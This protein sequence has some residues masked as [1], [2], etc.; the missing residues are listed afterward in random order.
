MQSARAQAAAAA[1]RR[2]FGINAGGLF[3]RPAGEWAPMLAQLRR[4]GL[5]VVRQDLSWAAVQP[6][7]DGPFTWAATDRIAEALATAGLRWYPV[8]AYSTAWSGVTPGDMMS[9]PAD[10]ARYAAYAAA[11]ARRYGAGGAFWSEHPALPVL[12]I[13]SYEIWNEPNAQRFWR[14]QAT[15]PEDYADLYAAARDAIHG[16]DSRARVVVGGLVEMGAM[17]FITRFYAARRDLRRRVDAIGF[18]VYGPS[19]GGQLQ[20]VSDFRITLQRLDPGVPLELTEAGF[21]GTDLAENAR[22]AHMTR[23]VQGVAMSR[24]NVQS[25]IPYAA[26]TSEAKAGDWEQWFGL[27]N[28]DATAKP[29]GQAY[30][31]AVRRALSLS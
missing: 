6:V 26:V 12:P 22:A 18:H 23:L 10:P 17:P 2:Q 1:R 13:A 20:A 28:A 31:T 19:A 3:A 11:V 4:A 15:A 30:G 24:L 27:W 29:S 9:R 5:T 16:A 14:E 7:A 21:S 25:L 8:L